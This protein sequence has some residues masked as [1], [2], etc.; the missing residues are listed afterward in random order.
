MP[1]GQNTFRWLRVFEM[2]QDF[3]N[4]KLLIES[5]GLSSLP[6]QGVRSPQVIAKQSCLLQSL[7]LSP[8]ST[9]SSQ[10]CLPGLRGT[11]CLSP[12]LP[13]PSCGLWNLP[14][15]GIEP[16]PSARG[17]RILTTGPPGNSLS[18][19]LICDSPSLLKLAPEF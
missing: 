3:G 7:F 4:A 13:S 2:D 15:P 12:T 11:I 14:Q 18:P 9:L 17:C 5:L 10:F 8:V 6:G 16:G 1:E 19:F